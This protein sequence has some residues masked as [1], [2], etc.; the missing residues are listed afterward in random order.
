MGQAGIHVGID[1]AKAKVDVAVR[2]TGE[3][4]EVPRDEAGIPQLVSEMKTLGPS[5]VLLEAT[6]GLELPLV[7]ALA[8]EALPVVVVNPRQVRDFA[9]ATGKLAKTDARDAAVLAAQWSTL[10]RLEPSELNQRYRDFFQTMIGDLRHEG[11][12][13]RSIAMAGNN[14]SFPT[15][16]AGISYNVGFWSGGGKPSLDVYLWIAAD[17]TERNKQIFDALSGYQDEIEGKLSGV[18]WDRRNNMRICSIYFSRGG[19]IASPEE[20]LV[21]LREWAVDQLVSLRAAFAPRLEK[22]MGDLPSNEPE[23]VRR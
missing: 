9:R 21:E 14:Q 17:E 22:V 1:V 4:W 23:E 15:D 20:D 5:L 2:P 11:F 7:A 6:G 18:T 8:A 3:R 10:T 19:S 12:T 13:D 16:F